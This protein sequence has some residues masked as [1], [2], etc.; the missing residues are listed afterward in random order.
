M[1]SNVKTLRRIAFSHSTRTRRVK[2]YADEA[3]KFIQQNKDSPLFLWWVVDPPHHPYKA[4]P[5]WH[6]TESKFL[7]T[8]KEKISPIIYREK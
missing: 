8:S 7:K 1:N 4:H 2:P 5:Y 6:S 3:I